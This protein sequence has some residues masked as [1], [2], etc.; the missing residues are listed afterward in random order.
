MLKQTQAPLKLLW[1]H[2]RARGTG[3]A[4]RYLMQVASA[5][6]EKGIVSSLLYGPGYS[7]PDF[8]AAFESAWPAL[9][10]STQIQKIQPDLIYV[11]RLPQG[12]RMQ[13]LLQLE[14]PVMRFFHDHQL[15]CLREHKYT[16]I[17]QKTCTRPLGTH[18][19][20]CPG[21]VVRSGSG[22]SLRSVAGMKQELDLH[23]HLAQAVVASDYLADHLVANGFEREMISVVPLFAS[24]PQPAQPALGK[25]AFD[26]WQLLF[27]GQLVTGKGLDLLLKALVKVPQAK[28]W[29]AG[30]GRQAEKYQQICEA[31][32]LRSRVQF[33]GNQSA[34]ALSQL[35]NQA[36]MV[37][38][39]SRAPETFALA[40]V[41]AM[42]HGRAVIASDVGG[43]RTWLNPGQNGLL[44]PSGDIQ[45]LADAIRQLGEAPELTAEMGSQGV[46]L[47]QEKF[48]L[49]QH[50][51]K[52]VPLMHR[53]VFES[54]Q[55]QKFNLQEAA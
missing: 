18:C 5:L 55:T 26:P 12:V 2:D 46:L 6:R 51:Q 35:Q 30:E 54:K 28:L 17:G 39:P 7:D 16:A 31:L 50:L 42:S 43:M 29:V 20:T 44:F 48:Q 37:V 49:S 1:I 13:D 40:G 22:I 52:L 11:H 25:P 24:A 45:A 41:E 32:G 19:Y 47:W 8:L 38:I 23:R 14:I 4:E 53:L 15:L 34:E 10:F 3:G 21:F 36:A 33:L 9:E 27:A